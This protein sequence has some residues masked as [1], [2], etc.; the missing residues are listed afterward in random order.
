MATEQQLARLDRLVWGLIF[1]GLFAMVLALACLAAAPAFAWTLIVVGALLA[2]AGS[3]LIVVR[4]RLPEEATPGAQST[5][6]SRRPD[7]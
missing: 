2:A 1:G 7:A 6:A 3:A 4:S 5:I